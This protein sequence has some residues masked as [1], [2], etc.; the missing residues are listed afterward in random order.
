M[1]KFQNF[2]C[3]DE[4]LV[5]RHK[6]REI[7]SLLLYSLFDIT[8]WRNLPRWFLSLRAER[9][10]LRD[11]LPWITYDATRYLSKIVTPESRVFEYSSGGS[12]I[13]FAKKAK[14]VISV[15]HDKLWYEKAKKDLKKLDLDNYNYLFKPPKKLHTNQEI[16]HDYYHSWREQ[17]VS[18]EDYVKTIDDYPDN[19]FDI[20]SVDGRSRVACVKEAYSKVKAG[21]YILLDNSDRKDYFEA[22]LFLNSKNCVQHDFFGLIGYETV[23]V[24]TTIWEVVKA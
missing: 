6:K 4:R 19:Y 2:F 18:F 1:N 22:I 5:Q 24:Q 3:F 10:P 23:L 8:Q 12:T 7:T 13:Y 17:G 14:E 20:I 16:L 11:G 9:T 15:E 21:G